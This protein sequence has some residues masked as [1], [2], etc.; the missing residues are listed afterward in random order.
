VRA[1]TLAGITP[2]C[3]SPLPRHYSTYTAAWSAARTPHESSQ[4]VRG[5]A[6]HDARTPSP[7][8]SL[9]RKEVQGQGESINKGKG[10]VPYIVY[11]TCRAWER[12][13]QKTTPNNNLASAAS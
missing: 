5:Q 1:G 6:L 7:E 8:F 4:S 3:Y 10:T 11:C 2:R 13:R 9:V 12:R